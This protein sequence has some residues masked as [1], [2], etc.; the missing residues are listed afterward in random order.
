MT[1]AG[2]K[3]CC[4]DFSVV[5]KMFD[6]FNKKKLHDSVI[7]GKCNASKRWNCIKSI[8]LTSYNVCFVF[9]YACFM[10]LS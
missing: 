10:C 6:R 7:T 9:A 5:L 3:E 8:F 4:Q 2:C 1:I